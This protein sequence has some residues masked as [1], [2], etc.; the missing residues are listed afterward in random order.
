MMLGACS[1]ISRLIQCTR[2]SSTS[3]TDRPE[4]V[5]SKSLKSDRPMS[6]SNDCNNGN[7]QLSALLSTT[8]LLPELPKIS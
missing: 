2:G 8:Q 6:L 4:P 5:S 1:L 3:D 7:H